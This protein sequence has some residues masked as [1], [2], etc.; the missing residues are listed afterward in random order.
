MGSKYEHVFSPIRIRG[1]DFK[2]RIE[3]APPSLNLAS[4]DHFVTHEIVD[5]NRTIAYG[6]SAVITVG[7]VIV[8][9]VKRRMRK[10][11]LELSSELHHSLSWFANVRGLR[12]ARSW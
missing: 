3:L 4:L 11:K 7:N 8:D 2:N 10:R 6:G 1:V 5:I 9:I 12:R